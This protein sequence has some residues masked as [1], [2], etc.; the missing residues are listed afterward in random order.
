MPV[1]PD[2]FHSKPDRQS[3]ICIE[4]NHGGS[5]LLMVDVEQACMIEILK[6][7]W[8]L[9]PARRHQRT[10]LLASQTLKEKSL[11]VPKSVHV[12]HNITYAR[13]DGIIFFKWEV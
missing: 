13:I 11:Q 1:Y 10:C 8:C 5:V 2:I 7:I 3:L 9:F 4:G 6:S 12:T